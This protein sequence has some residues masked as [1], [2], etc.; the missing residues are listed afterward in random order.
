MVSRLRV[1]GDSCCDDFNRL[2]QLIVLTAGTNLF[3]FSHNDCHV[4]TKLFPA[5]FHVMTKQFPVLFH[6]MRKLFPAL[7]HVMRK[8]YSSRFC[9]RSTT[10]E[11]CCSFSVKQCNCT[12]VISLSKLHATRTDGLSGRRWGGGRALGGEGFRVLSVHTNVA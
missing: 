11:L 12:R 6:V 10:R 1:A 3:G 4:M 7:I 8:L 5:L 2:L 9:C